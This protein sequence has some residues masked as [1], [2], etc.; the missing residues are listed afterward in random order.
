MH[1]LV[2]QGLPHGVELRQQPLAVGGGAMTFPQGLKDGPVAAKCSLEGI[3]NFLWR[4]PAAAGPG[5]ARR[6]RLLESL[7]VGH[8]VHAGRAGGPGERDALAG[9]GEGRAIQHT[10]ISTSKHA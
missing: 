2:R 8:G 1:L 5:R 7:D 3:R 6:P 9:L 10:S 4:G